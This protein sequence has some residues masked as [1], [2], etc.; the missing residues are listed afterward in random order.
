M[1]DKRFPVV[2]AVIIGF[3]ASI[4]IAIMVLLFVE[5]RFF[6]A[7]VRELRVL[8]QQYAECVDLLTKKMNDSVV[9]NDNA[10]IA[11]EI[12]TELP[13]EM[14]DEFVEESPI[15]M[16]EIMA[17]E[18]SDDPDDDDEYVDDS[19]VV[20]NR[21]SDYLKQSTLDYMES[22]EL[23]S[24]MTAIDVDRW[25]DYTEVPPLVPQQ[26]KPAPQNR[27]TVKPV[28]KPQ[29]KINAMRRPIKDCGFMWPIDRDKFWLSSL[30]GPRKRIDGTW[31]FHHGIDMAAVKGTVVKSARAGLVTEACFQTG[32]GNT[33]VVKHTDSLKTR[34]AHLHTIHV[35]AGQKIKQGS[36][37]GTVGETGFIRKK[38]KDGS[39]LHFEV[40]EKA[41]RINPMHCL[42]RTA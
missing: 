1:I 2:Y 10:V 21:Q 12:S 22:Q 42:P 29:T 7:Q 5:Y 16:D 9:I 37:V 23:N 13:D 38:G 4:M 25:S 40:Y 28:N 36:V 3:L 18:A 27:S 17:A 24:L 32:Y 11:S 34:Y 33:V 26:K 15:A 19:F 20:I 6:C 31:G 35:C 30:F 8:K 14:P 41:K 39:H